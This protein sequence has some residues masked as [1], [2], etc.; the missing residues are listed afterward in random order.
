LRHALLSRRLHERLDRLDHPRPHLGIVDL[1]VAFRIEDLGDKCVEE[2]VD[3]EE[4]IVAAAAG[5]EPETL[6]ALAL[7]A[8]RRLHLS[9]QKSK[10]DCH[11]FGMSSSVKPPWTRR[12]FQ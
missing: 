8:K 10:K 2:D 11:A 4:G 6:D 12:F 1:Q 9:H 5:A 7:G 3:V